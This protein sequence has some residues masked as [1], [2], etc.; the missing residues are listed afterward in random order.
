[1]RFT[2]SLV[3]LLLAACGSPTSDDPKAQLEA[4][5]VSDQAHRTEMQQLAT[6]KGTTSVA[7]LVLWAKQEFNDWANL[8]RLERLVQKSGWPRRS[9]VGYKGADAAF[10]VLQHANP[11]K[12][13][14]YLPLLQAAVTEGEARSDNLALLEDRIL[15]REG[16]KQ[17]Y[18]S[19]LQN[20]GKGGWELYPIEDEATVDEKRKTVGLGPLAEYAKGF[21]VVYQPVGAQQAVPA[22]A[23]ASRAGG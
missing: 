6:T 16:K 2:V 8:R 15:M 5:Y 17:K 7:F 19:Q 14:Q 12:Q 21:G 1:M 20:N 13:K 10:L 9:V 4:M 11:A 23:A 3:V 22:D 18:G